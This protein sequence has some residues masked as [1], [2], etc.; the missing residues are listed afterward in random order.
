MIFLLNFL[1]TNK[2]V[3]VAIL[4]AFCEFLPEILNVIHLMLKLII[5]FERIIEIYLNKSINSI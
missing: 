1:P 4:V 5:L 2:K 3:K